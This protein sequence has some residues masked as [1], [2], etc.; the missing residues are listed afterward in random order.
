M[1]P[2]GIMRADEDC[3][4]MNQEQL[5]GGTCAAASRSLP[6]AQTFLRQLADSAMSILWMTNSDDVCT[7]LNKST[8]ELFGNAGEARVSDWFA[9]VHRDDL[10]TVI[11]TFSEAKNA[12][13]E[14]QRQYRIIRSDG[15][16]RW[17]L[18]SGAPRF[19]MSGE[20]DGYN[21]AI[22]DI[23][24]QCDAFERLATSQA[25]YRLLADN[26]SDLISHC[27][28][29]GTYIYASP[30]FEKALGYDAAA[31]A[32]RSAYDLIHPD[33]RKAVQEEVAKQLQT[34]DDSRVIEIRKLHA[35]RHYVW[36]GVKLRVLTDPITKA[37]TG[38][39][40]ISRDITLELAER[41]KRRQ[42][43]KRFRSL[44]GLSS[45]WYW[46]TDN[47]SRFTFISDG[48]ERLY[49]IPATEAIGKS[50][51]ERA[52]DKN[53]PGLRTYLEKIQKR[54]AFKDIHYS[55]YARDKKRIR[56]AVLSGE[57]V[58][59]NGVF[60]GYRGVGR[61]VTN[62]MEA[63]DK[64]SELAAE[65]RALIDNSL[66]IIASVDKR[67]RILRL[68]AAV[69][70]ILGFLPAECVGKRY[71]DFLHPEE[72][73]GARALEARLRTGETTIR[74]FETRGMRKNG[75]IAYLSLSLRWSGEQNLMYV[76]AR[77]VTERL[78]IQTEVQRS[79]DQ[80]SAMLESIGDAF[81]AVDRNW[82]ITYVN[83]KG[84]RFVG[85][86]PDG[87]LGKIA[88][89]AVPA[90]RTSA[91]FPYYEKV[92]AT[93]E[94]LS[95]EELWEPSQ[96][97]IDV[98]VYPHED[99]IAVYF[100]DVSARRQAEREI[101]ESEQRLREI[102][103]MTPAG[104]LLA[105][106]AASIVDVNQALCNFVGSSRDELVGQNL[107]KLFSA[108]PWHG[109]LSL[110]HGPT[111]AHG[112]EAL[113]RQKEGD[114]VPVL[115]S[116]RIKRD[117][118]GNAQSFTA[119]LTDI[120]ERKQAESR[121]RH[122]ATHDVLTGLPN[123][124]LINQRLQSMLDAASPDGTI[125]VMFIDLDRFKD[126]NDSMGHSP[127]DVLLRQVAMRLQANMR[128]GDIVARL[129]GDEFV[130]TAYCSDGRKSASAIAEKLLAALATPFEIEGLGVI[131]SASIGISMFA[132]GARTKE[133]LF[134]NADT[135]MY[136]AKASGRNGYR[137]FETAMSTEAK[138]RMTLEHSL[139]DALER[140]EFELH[141]QPRIDL[142]TMA[143]V[144]MEALIRWNHPQ[145]GRIPPMQFIP[146]A[147]DC[148]L[149][150]SIGEW[151]LAEACI[152]TARLS[153]KLGRALQISVNLSACQL[154]C[155]TLVE[156]V[157]EALSR[158][159]L[160][161]ELLELELTETALVGDMDKSVEVLK[162]LK[163]LGLIL[164]VDDF[165]TGYSGLSYLKR[166]PVDILKLDR[167]FVLQQPDGVSS[168]DFIK[169]FVDM[170]HALELSVVAE[171]VETKETL[172][173]ICA[174]A[175]D[176]AQGYYFARPLPLDELQEFLANF[177]QADTRSSLLEGR[178]E[179]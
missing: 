48:F 87:I 41:N 67:G 91:I 100:H 58:F 112:V 153:R 82:R 158:S 33:D 172:E 9:F 155:E 176:G 108:C 141:Y 167:S 173:L 14:Y 22:L 47:N 104:Y 146:I 31:M 162:R 83:R 65:N 126:V 129:G 72:L 109:A 1:F 163:R 74:D 123:R 29:D 75:S 17:M 115:F 159:G 132:D 79:K 20:F 136:R 116:G 95:F 21:G 169:A 154:K 86:E 97:W 45:D 160:A 174:A 44:A 131:I 13:Q 145:L 125:A 143:V 76:T 179:P 56:R 114:E 63:A 57:P 137:F 19:T 80:M 15:T 118:E 90:L 99:G 54:E 18:G 8:L 50:R 84:A 6:D 42:S 2:T 171:G 93:R 43:E 7:F 121:L 26:S 28:P 62:E 88:W 81:F 55:A 142:K 175:C 94:P 16:V 166:F 71:S 68:S 101:R 40:S 78:Q 161:P 51:Q 165:G 39:V 103:E 52:A 92:M 119:F 24:A 130:V 64:L 70:D 5:G 69:A 105:D 113:L 12:R 23:T 106:A 37:K 149:V 98:R 96:A 156:Q 49:G 89:E 157:V 34:A 38:T 102:L 46:E 164:S 25:E 35:L 4:P 60:S 135:A 10:E 178:T 73:Q 144:G 77:D 124:E 85:V 127:G 107:E 134:Q 151:V 11:T 147:E 138:L 122:Q 30:S 111:V 168:F 139:R 53:H 120:T 32:G 170:A 150:E 110:R 140:E 61:D 66:D 152:Q 117:R 177:H 133:L 27:A 128:P 59:Q 3:G 36:M 148:G